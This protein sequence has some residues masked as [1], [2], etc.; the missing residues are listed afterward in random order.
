MKKLNRS[1]FF[2]LL[3]V[4]CGCKTTQ[5]DDFHANNVEFIHSVI[6]QAIATQDGFNSCQY[7]CQVYNLVLQSVNVKKHIDNVQV[8][9]NLEKLSIQFFGAADSGYQYEGIMKLIL[10][11]QKD[12]QVK[13]WLKDQ[14]EFLNLYLQAKSQQEKDAVLDKYADHLVKFYQIDQR[15]TVLFG[16]DYYTYNAH[17]HN[18]K[19]LEEISKIHDKN[20]EFDNYIGAVDTLILKHA[21]NSIEL[22]ENRL[23]KDLEEIKKNHAFV[24]YYDPVAVDFMRV[25]GLIKLA[26]RDSQTRKYLQVTLNFFENLNK[27]PQGKKRDALID[28]FA[29]EIVPS[30]SMNLRNDTLVEIKNREIR[31]IAECIVAIETRKPFDEDIYKHVAQALVIQ[32]EMQ[33]KSD[34]E[35]AYKTD[36]S[37]FLLE[38]NTLDNVEKFRKMEEFAPRYAQKKACY[39]R[40]ILAPVVT[41]NNET[42]I[43]YFEI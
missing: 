13:I 23:K 22:D 32:E 28:S 18:K 24:Y 27:M 16:I 37:K 25:K 9:Q 29:D 33:D 10:L 36:F 17:L 14:Y 20:R 5:L 8:A 26:K 7:R 38:M 34:E 11:A 40:C 31:N 4:F 43:K 15:N 2:V 6:E 21:N 12:D 42:L 41:P 3:L 30:L 35:K 39:S 1:Y 19:Y